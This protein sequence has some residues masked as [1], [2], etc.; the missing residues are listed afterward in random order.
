MTRCLQ[1][2]PLPLVVPRIVVRP[3]IGIAAGEDG[4]D[5]V[6][7][8]VINGWKLRRRLRFDHDAAALGK[9]HRLGGTKDPALV[10]GVDGFHAG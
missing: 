9:I 8:L 2:E 3:V 10:D 1:I 5:F 7:P 6:E 4:V